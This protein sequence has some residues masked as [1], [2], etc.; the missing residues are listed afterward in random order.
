MVVDNDACCQ[1]STGGKTTGFS[2]PFQNCETFRKLFLDLFADFW[3]TKRATRA[4]LL[5]KQPSYERLL[6]INLRRSP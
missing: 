2:V 6:V 5:E 4:L 3:E 1:R